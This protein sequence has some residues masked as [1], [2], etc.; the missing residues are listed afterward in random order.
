MAGLIADAL[1]GGAAGTGEG[2]A[3]A[4]TIGYKAEVANQ[5][6]KL[7]NELTA[8][9]EARNIAL[10]GEQHRLT[11][12]DKPRTI[13]AGATERRQGEAD[14]QAPEKPLSDEEKRLKTAEAL[15]KEA[16]ARYLD[17][18][19]DRSAKESKPTLPK[20]IAIKDAEGNVVGALD[21]H[22]GAFG[23]PT[24]GAPAKE[25]VSHWFSADEPAKPA[26]PPG[27]RWSNAAGQPIQGLHVYY[28]EMSG[29]MSAGGGAPSAPAAPSPDPLGLRS[30]LP[31]RQPQGAGIVS[32]APA[33]QP[34]ALPVE[35][36]LTRS[37]G[38]FMFQASP[39]S[40]AVA[41]QLNGRTFPNQ[42]AAQ[43]AYDELLNGG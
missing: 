41:K 30:S 36:F 10:T 18:E 7:L 21:E 9:R 2:M 5:H 1:L 34:Q 16:Y 13:Q 20:I 39:R 17:R 24:P 38:G 6:A 28:P 4:G 19:K 32:S 3:T 42:Q 29:R 11:E 26:V 43:D 23:T 35:Q 8:A 25:A 33:P 12:R 14:F 37:R 27:L 31:K 15:S 22:S 40:S